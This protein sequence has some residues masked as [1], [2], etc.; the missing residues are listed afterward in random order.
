[1]NNYLI[2][3]TK[4]YNGVKYLYRFPNNYGASVVQH[5]LSYGYKEGLWEIGVV[6]FDGDEYHLTYETP[7]TRDVIGY[8]TWE[9]IEEQLELIKNLE[10]K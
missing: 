3:T 6:E 8:L 2:E 9:Q 7:I 1:M 5:E 10:A 4:P